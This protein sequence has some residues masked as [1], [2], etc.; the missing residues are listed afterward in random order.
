MNGKQRH[1]KQIKKIMID[2]ILNYTKLLKKG[3]CK[4]PEA[5]ELLNLVREDVVE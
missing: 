5:I 4:L 2:A 3:Q 1:I